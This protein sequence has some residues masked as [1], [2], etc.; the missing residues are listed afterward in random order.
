MLIELWTRWSEI[1][2]I[3]FPVLGIE[4]REVRF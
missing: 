1:E 2:I 3:D 4:L